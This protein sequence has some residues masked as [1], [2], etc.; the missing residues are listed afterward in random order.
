MYAP[1]NINLY[2]ITSIND[3]EK[4]INLYILPCPYTAL[5]LNTIMSLQAENDCTRAGLG[6][7]IFLM[8]CFFLANYINCDT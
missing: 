2:L 7:E 5:Y 1:N 3:C 4:K 8:N 6:F